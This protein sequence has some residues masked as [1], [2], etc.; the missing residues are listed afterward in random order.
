MPPKLLIFDMGHVF[1]DF[2]WEDICGE[3]CS[4]TGV[5]RSELNDALGYLSSLGYEKGNIS[6]ADFLSEA[7]KKLKTNLHIDEFHKIWNKN[8][9]ENS[10]MAALLQ[11]LRTERPLYLLSNTNES[12]WDYLENNFHVSRHF[13]ERILSFQVRTSKPDKKIY[14]EVLKRSG[15]L[16]SECLFVD[17]LEENIQAAK[18]IGMQGIRFQGID[19]LK[20]ELAL[21]GILIKE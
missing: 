21:H 7:N 18:N 1:V 11:K 17:D 10:E 6:T 3:F 16:A 8:H 14:E 2:D 4:K 13:E 9:L 5:A 15:H 12:H 20:K 19:H